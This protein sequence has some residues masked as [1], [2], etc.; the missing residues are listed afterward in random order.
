MRMSAGRESA[1]ALWISG[2]ALFETAMVPVEA[3]LIS[4]GVLFMMVMGWWR[5]FTCCRKRRGWRET[6]MRR[7]INRVREAM[8]LPESGHANERRAG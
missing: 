1:E 2:G 7:G 5:C 6:T 3:L 4:G 8:N